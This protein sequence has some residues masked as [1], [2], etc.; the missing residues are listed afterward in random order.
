LLQQTY[1]RVIPISTHNFKEK[2][3]LIT[4]FRLFNNNLLNL[5]AL[6]EMITI[7]KK[8]HNKQILKSQI[9]QRDF[10]QCNIPVFYMLITSKNLIE[11]SNKAVVLNYFERSPLDQLLSRFRDIVKDENFLPK[12]LK[13]LEAKLKSLKT[14]QN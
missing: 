5:D 10:E 13:E 14:I 9:V 2:L 8:T 1:V 4:E 3:E 6:N 7:E 11:T 12:L